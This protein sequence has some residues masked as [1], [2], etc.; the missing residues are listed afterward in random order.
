MSLVYCFIT[1]E[2]EPLQLKNG[3]ALGNGK[4]YFGT[5]HN[6]MKVQNTCR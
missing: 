1:I 2:M 4:M 6:A 5:E 3:K